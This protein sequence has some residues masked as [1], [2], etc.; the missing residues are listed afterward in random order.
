MFGLD[1]ISI[2]FSFSY[3]WLIT[4]IALAALYS[5][6]VYRYTI[7]KISGFKKGLLISLRILALILIVILIFDPVI[8]L[9]YIKNLEPENL[10]FIDNSASLVNKDSLGRTNKINEFITQLE[11]GTTKTEFFTFDGEVEKTEISSN[12]KILFDGSRTNFNK[13]INFLSTSE[14]NIASAIII[15]DGILNDGINPEY[16]AEKLPFPIYTVGIGD[17]SIQKDITVKNILFNNYIYLNTPTVIS[18]SV[19]N[20]G[21]GGRKV[22]ASLFEGNKL[23]LQKPITLESSGNNNLEFDYTPETPGEKKMS[24]KISAFEDE[25][26]QENNRSLFFI[27]VLNNKLKILLIAGAPSADL[28]FI[29]ESLGSDENYE[30][31]SITQITSNRIL[32]GDNYLEKIDNSDIL[33]LVGFPAESTQLKLIDAVKQTIKEKRKPFFILIQPA[34]SFNKLKNLSEILP[35]EFN[36]ENRGV[37]QV[38]PKILDITNPLLGS[39]ITDNSRN[40]NNLPPI[41]SLNSGFSAKAGAKVLVSAYVRGINIDAP[42]I[43]TSRLGKQSSIALL[44][45]DIWRWKLQTAA[46][47]NPTFDS[48]LSAAVKWLNVT[49]EQ[50]QLTVKT[51]KKLY[52]MRESIKFTAQ[53]YDETFRPV[54]DAEVKIKI[55]TDG[56]ESELILDPGGN[57]IYTGEFETKK[58]GDFEYK[59]SSEFGG[60]IS[61]KADGSFTV[62][63]IDIEK[64]ETKADFNLLYSIAKASGGKFTTIEGYQNLLNEIT[65]ENNSNN[66][67]FIV[68]DEFNLLS[69]ERILFLIILLLGIEWFVRKKSGL[70]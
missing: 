6:F 33:F 21:Y 42:L 64:I 54:N 41:P 26:T 32:E 11:S 58:T 31:N 53:V 3:F 15:S 8:S 16:Q 45:G 69:D 19:L 44:A 9:K 20:N 66:S 30:V 2:D 56:E 59:A 4:G 35:F 23:I 22:T 38:Q 28:K 7:P 36:P 68:T 57:G 62:G 12:D 67:E 10:V 24:I 1:S 52:T 5:F 14:N 47:D 51:D 60:T 39:S 48:F 25:A 50:K 13:I 43:I 27:N 61:G 40:W 17:T 70:L 34:V 29:K 65:A 46:K 49:E 37:I 18:A 63:D 55:I